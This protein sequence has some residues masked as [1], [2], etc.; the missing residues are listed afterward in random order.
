MNGLMFVCS[1][2]PSV[3]NS[4]TT[5]NI[6]FTRWLDSTAMLYSCFFK[7]LGF[8]LTKTALKSSCCL[9]HLVSAANFSA[10]FRCSTFFLFKIVTLKQIWLLFCRS[11]Q[12]SNLMAWT[13]Q[14]NSNTHQILL[15]NHRTI[16]ATKPAKRKNKHNP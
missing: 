16:N 3:I 12:Q 4:D 14:K 15:H 7:F 1:K 10:F 6:H 11:N 8:F 9:F 2:C 13:Y 5:Q